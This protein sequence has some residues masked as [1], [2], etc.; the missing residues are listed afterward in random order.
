M[1]FR[2][3]FC[4]HN[5]VYKYS[6]LMPLNDDWPGDITAVWACTKCG[7]ENKVVTTVGQ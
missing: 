5:Y 2:R 4:M 1:L 7:K 3:L 6:E